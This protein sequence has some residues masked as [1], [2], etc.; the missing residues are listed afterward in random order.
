MKKENQGKITLAL[1]TK[2]TILGLIAVLLFCLA[3][4]HSKHL[5]L[6]RT[7][8]IVEFIVSFLIFGY[9]KYYDRFHPKTKKS[10]TTKKRI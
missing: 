3:I 9:I 2:Q 6:Y 8:V 10:K 1:N 5:D 4:Y 7:Y